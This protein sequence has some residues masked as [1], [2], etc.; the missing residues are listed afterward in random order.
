MLIWKNGSGWLFYYSV[1]CNT[2]NSSTVPNYLTFIDSSEQLLWFACFAEKLLVLKIM[3]SIWKLELQM[4]F[5]R[6]FFSYI[7]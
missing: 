3:F 7:L 5:L 1:S 6:A 2:E 4:S